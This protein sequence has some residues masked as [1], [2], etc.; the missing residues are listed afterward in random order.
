MQHTKQHSNT[1]T[2]THT[3]SNTPRQNIVLGQN[4]SVLALCLPRVVVAGAGARPNQHSLE[5]NPTRTTLT[6]TVY[7]RINLPTM[8]ETC[9]SLG[10]RPG[11]S[12]GHEGPAGA[13]LLEAAAEHTRYVSIV[14]AYSV[15][16]FGVNTYPPLQQSWL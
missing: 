1:H 12:G 7:I 10:G 3:H 2:H 9:A 13:V 5:P 16:L 11:G 14:F 6:S 15:E 8:P 4:K